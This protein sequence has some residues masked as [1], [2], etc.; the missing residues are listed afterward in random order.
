MRVLESVD[1]LYSFVY[2]MYINYDTFLL[3]ASSTI[4]GFIQSHIASRYR[5]ICAKMKTLGKD[6]AWWHLG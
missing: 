2:L 3:I 5:Q 6:S 1:T 4:C